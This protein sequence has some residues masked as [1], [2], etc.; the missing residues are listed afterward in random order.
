MAALFKSLSDDMEKVAQVMEEGAKIIMGTSNYM[1]QPSPNDNEAHPPTMKG[2]DVGDDSADAAFFDEEDGGDYGSPLMGMADSVLS[3]IMSAQ[4]R[5]CL[6]LQLELV[7]TMYM[8]T[9]FS[10]LLYRSLRLVPKRPWNT[11]KH[12]QQQ[13]L[14]TNPSSDALLRSTSCLSLLR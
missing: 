5:A 13:L 3:D 9:H 10:I 8:C 2:F 1:G 12:S 4:V 11:F 6:L 7:L 14:G